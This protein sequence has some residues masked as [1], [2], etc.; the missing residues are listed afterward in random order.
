[1]ARAGT[2]RARLARA[3]AHP[4]EEY[5]GYL[6]I[7]QL[8]SDYPFKDTATAVTFPTPNDLSQQ[9]ALLHVQ[10]KLDWLS[11]QNRLAEHYHQQRNG[12]MLLKT[13][14]IIAD[15]LPHDGKANLQ[16][17]QIL[18]QAGRKAAA[19]HYLQ[20][21]LLTDPIPELAQKLMQQLN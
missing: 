9:L 5:A 2:G 21:A 8:T 6:R 11:M 14:L 19:K 1:M 4:A 7:L 13:L 20:R 10:G 15:A 3:P 17:A 12:D 18:L 16:A